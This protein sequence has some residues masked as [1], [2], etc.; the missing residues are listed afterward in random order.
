MFYDKTNETEEERF[1]GAYLDPTQ[2]ST[3]KLS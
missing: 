3:M 1:L 2:T